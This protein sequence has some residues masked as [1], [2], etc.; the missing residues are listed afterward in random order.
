M[1][2]DR[3]LSRP[4][5]TR[6]GVRSI[7]LTLGD[8]IDMIDEDLSEAVRSQPHWQLTRLKLI[9]AAEKGADED[10]DDATAQLMVALST[11]GQLEHI[12]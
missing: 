12:R 4:I 8:A 7:L 10:S 9:E 6:G 3:P 2:W 5:R 11:E 1:N